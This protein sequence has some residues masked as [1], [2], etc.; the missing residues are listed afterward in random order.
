M[1][2]D[3]VIALLS[4]VVVLLL[5]GVALWWTLRHTGPERAALA[6]RIG[7]LPLRNKVRLALALMRERRIPLAVRAVPAF[8]ALYLAMP[9]DLIPDVIPVLGQLDDLLV[10]G[11]G[12]ALMLRLVPRETL[13][14]HIERLE[15]EPVKAQD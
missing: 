3:W 5:L 4:I 13:E 12:V 10:L 15:R 9:I 8:L 14:E 1:S 6:K 2:T 7:A 11:L